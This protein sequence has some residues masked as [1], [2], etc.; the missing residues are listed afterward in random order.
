[1]C[2]THAKPKK[3]DSPIKVYKAILKKNIYYFDGTETYYYHTPF[4]NVYLNKEVI[5]NGGTVE[6]RN[7]EHVPSYDD[8]VRFGI[9]QGYVHAYSDIETAA[10]EL[11]TFFRSHIDRGMQK[12]YVDESGYTFSSLKTE[13]WEC[14]VPVSE[15]ENYC[16]EGLFDGNED[17]GSLCARRMKFVRKVEEDELNN[18]YR[19]WQEKKPIWGLCELPLN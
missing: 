3:V 10:S 13:I 15:D 12:L 18:A 11:F 14:E 8:I 9:G 2:I 19:E 6:A 17:I 16:W 4:Y 7:P 1:M 5:E